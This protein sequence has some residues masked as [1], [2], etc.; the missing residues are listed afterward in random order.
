MILLILAVCLFWK[1]EDALKAVKLDP[2]YQK[3][4]LRAS[5]CALQRGDFVA[6]RNMYKHAGTFATFFP[7]VLCAGMASAFWSLPFRSIMLLQLSSFSFD[8]TSTSIWSFSRW[9][10]GRTRTKDP[11]S[12][13]IILCG[14]SVVGKE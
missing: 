5:E 2:T 10:E 14:S 6:A 3:G 4:H 11:E 13:A 7:F 1:E 9:Q 8:Y 12:R